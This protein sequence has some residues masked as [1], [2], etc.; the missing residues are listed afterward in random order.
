MLTYPLLPPLKDGGA[1]LKILP[2]K[3][4]WQKVPPV[5][6]K[7]IAENLK[8]TKVT[9]KYTDIDSIPSMWARPLLFQIALY[10]TDHPMHDIIVGEWRGLL[11]MLALKERRNFPLTTKLITIPPADDDNTPEFLRALRK[12]IPEQTL[13][14]NTTWDNL[15]LILFKGNPIGITSPTTLL[16]TSIDYTGRISNV[17]WYDGQFLCDPIKYLNPEEKAAVAGWLTHFHS[18]QINPL[19]DSTPNLNEE[20][21]DQIVFIRNCLNGQIRDFRGDLGGEPQTIPEF[22]DTGIGIEQGFFVGMN[23]PIAKMDFLTQKLFVIKYSDAFCGTLT[24]QVKGELTVKGRQVTPI[25]PIK[26]EMLSELNVSDLNNQVTFEKTENGIKVT[27]RIPSGLEITQEYIEKEEGVEPLSESREIVEIDDVPVLEIWPN[28]KK[29]DWQVYYTYFTS[30]GQ[31]TFHAGPYGSQDAQQTVHGTSDIEK[32]ITKTS[33]FPEIMVCKYKDTSDY[34]EA[35]ILLVSDP[36]PL[37]DGERTWNIGIDFGTSSTTVYRNDIHDQQNI[38]NKIKLTNRLFQVTK[39]GDYRERLYDDFF[40][41]KDEPEQT[42]FHSFF[43]NFSGSTNKGTLEPLLNGHIHFVSNYQAFPTAQQIFTNLKWSPHADDRIRARVFLEQLCLQ[44]VAEAATEHVRKINWQFSYPIAFSADDR[45]GFRQI[46]Q[47]ITETCSTVTGLQHGEVSS[48]PESIAA[49]KFFASTR[50]SKDAIG[51]FA[52]GAVCIDIGGETS[53]ISIWQYNKLFWQASLRFAGRRI[54]LDILRENPEFLESLDVNPSDIKLLKDASK[55][56]ASDFYAQADAWITESINSRTQNDQHN[57]WQHLEIYTGEPQVKTFIQLVAL[58][59]SGLLYYIGLI[60]KRL[61]QTENFERRM[62]SVYIGGN[63]ARI[64]HWLANGKFESDE[65]SKTRLKQILLDAS[66]FDTDLNR[67]DL[68][69]S[70]SPK[71]EASYGLVQAGT[72]LE[73][74]Q[75]QLGTTDVLAGETFIEKGE[76][77]AWTEILTPERLAS[78]LDTTGQLELEQIRDFVE[79]FNKNGWSGEKITLDQKTHDFVL[80]QLQN[81]LQKFRND[82]PENL[83]IEPLFI[84]ALKLLLE[85]KTNQWS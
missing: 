78:G 53:D 2:K 48:E 7:N 44:C 43:Q 8:V 29:T 27:L 35:G 13:D 37:P 23:K 33:H 25:L 49:A 67:F 30:A 36:D 58:G 28:F 60:L 74:T 9:G 72:F 61:S 62:P 50:Q 20:L 32:E 22:S 21:N 63:G 19:P 81:T 76:K 52:T 1:G 51:A 73:W 4:T 82:T 6:L 10:D 84:L 12:L 16:C 3:G 38:P 83:H 45:E 65:I 14:I 26:D 80:A 70:K 75:D 59:I 40:S 39:S 46:W 15:Y 66:G 68:E 17:G 71:E 24:P 69:I 42:P 18:E 85:W 79:S 56:K 77:R 31:D 34:Q 54:L 41:P 64:L 5:A 47:R 57:W 55:K 11:T